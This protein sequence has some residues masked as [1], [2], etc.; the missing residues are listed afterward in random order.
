MGDGMTDPARDGHRVRKQD[1]AG[2][3]RHGLKSSVVS[4]RF[5]EAYRNARPNRRGRAHLES[6]QGIVRR[7]RRHEDRRER[8]HRTVH[9]SDEARLNDLEHETSTTVLILFATLIG[10]QLLILSIG[11]AT[12]VIGLRIGEIAKQ[13]PDMRVGRSCRATANR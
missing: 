9:E 3:A 4:Q 10:R 5:R 13:L 7:E 12:L 2:R 6:V 1:R 11:G 8:R